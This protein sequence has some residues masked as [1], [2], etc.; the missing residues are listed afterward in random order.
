MSHPIVQVLGDVLQLSSAQGL[1]QALR[2]EP[3]RT[4]L[5]RAL[6]SLK[7]L[8]T[9]MAIGRG[10]DMYGETLVDYA[11][12]SRRRTLPRALSTVGVLAAGVG[13]GVGAAVL[14]APHVRTGV[15]SWVKSRS[16]S[17]SVSAPSSGNNAA[18]SPSHAQPATG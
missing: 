15:M 10:I 9:G 4:V 5:S 6:S 17:A 13:I 12:R 3:R 18:V 1:L 14:L 8:G 2:L 16:P 11:V 7:L